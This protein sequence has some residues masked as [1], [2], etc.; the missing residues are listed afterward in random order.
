MHQIVHLNCHTALVTFQIEKQI[1][2]NNTK[3]LPDIAKGILPSLW[4]LDTFLLSCY[5]WPGI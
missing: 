4:K 3:F 5:N 1:T 2:M